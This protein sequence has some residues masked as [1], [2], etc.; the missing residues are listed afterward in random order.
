MVLWAKT[1]DYA[2]C[3]ATYPDQDGG[4]IVTQLTQMNVPYRFMREAVL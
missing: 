1:T 3:S 4:A 2:H